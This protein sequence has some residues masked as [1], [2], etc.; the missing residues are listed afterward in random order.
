MPVQSML[1][2]LTA[3]QCVGLTSVALQLPKTLPLKEL[4]VSGNAHAASCCCP[5]FAAEKDVHA[6]VS[7]KCADCW[8][9]CPLL[10]VQ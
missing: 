3:N 2:S 1:E 5:F 6:K 7:P 4:S 8:I 9:A 10:H